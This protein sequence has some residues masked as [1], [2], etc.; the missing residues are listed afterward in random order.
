[1]ETI[2]LGAIEIR[3]LVDEALSSGSMTMFEVRVPSGAKV[4]VPHSHDAFDET[5]YGLKGIT[6]FTV[7]GVAH[8]LA[9]SD[10]VFIPRG[11]THG[12]V[13][14]GEEDAV[15]LAVATP[16]IFGAAYFRELRE[17]LAAAAGGPPDRVALQE[18]MRRHGLS[19]A[20]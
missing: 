16:G 12:F 8:Q 11:V 10:A 1:M 15:F 4:P 14:S 9:A 18:V 17:V 3:F 20:P 6:A 19:P 2:H 7:D 13:N 5:I